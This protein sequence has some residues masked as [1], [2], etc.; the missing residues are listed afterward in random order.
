MR[1][2]GQKL[3]IAVGT[4]IAALMLTLGVSSVGATAPSSVDPGG[5]T[6]VIISNTSSP[7]NTNPT[8]TNTTYRDAVRINNTPLDQSGGF[9]GQGNGLDECL[10]VATGNVTN[11]ANT[12]TVDRTPFDSPPPGCSYAPVGPIIQPAA[13]PLWEVQTGGPSNATNVLVVPP[14][15]VPGNTTRPSKGYVI[16]TFR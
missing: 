3:R 2:S 4:G 16:E 12:S 8:R 9:L 10:Y 11:A 14:T 1:V 13:Y 7:V 6:V 5:L 15:G